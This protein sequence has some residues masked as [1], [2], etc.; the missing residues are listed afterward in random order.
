MSQDSII[1]QNLREAG[2]GKFVDAASEGID[3]VCRMSGFE[4]PSQLVRSAA[5]L[6]PTS[7]QPGGST[8]P[9]GGDGMGRC[10]GDGLRQMIRSSYMSDCGRI[11]EPCLE[12]AIMLA[13]LM[14]SWAEVRDDVGIP[15][16]S[17][18]PSGLT[19]TGT[20][21][22]GQPTTFVS[23]FNVAPG[24]SILFKSQAFSLPWNPRC[25]W[26]TL[27]FAGG[28]DDANYKHVNFKPWVG[29]ADLTALTSLQ[30]GALREWNPRRWIFGSEFRCGDSC[31]EIPLRSY[32]GCTEIDIVGLNSALYLQV[33]NLNTASQAITGQQLVVRLGGFKKPCCDSCASGKSCS[34]SKH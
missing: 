2:L 19:P 27:A 5:A 30:N 10:L 17:F 22:S 31:Q 7:T 16:L 13:V 12:D 8:Q 21:A 23:S 9:S 32:T 1:V 14:S 29:P 4:R 34:C 25:L 24:Q 3:V 6:P 26:G 20:A 28:T 18:T 33:D 11:P 15:D